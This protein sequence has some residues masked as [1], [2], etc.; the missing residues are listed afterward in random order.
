VS[1]ATSYQESSVGPD[2]FYLKLIAE[3]SWEPANRDSMVLWV[4]PFDPFGC[5]DGQIIC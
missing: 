5:P 1:T 4:E 3:D 2:A